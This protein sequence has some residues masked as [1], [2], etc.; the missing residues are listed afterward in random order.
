MTSANDTT[1]QF[2]W[3]NAPWRSA[4]GR[5][6]WTAFELVVMVLGFVVFWPIGLAIL[7]YKMWTRRY[8]GADLQTVATAAYR[9]ARD[10]MSSATPKSGAY[11]DWRGFASGF[12]SRP[13]SSGNRAFDDWKTTQIA[14]LEEERRKLDEQRRKLDEAHKEFDAFVEQVRQAKDREEFERFMRERGQNNG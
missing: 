5:S 2:D 13:A 6:H 3:A 9:Q 1:G 10:A 8:G 14:R 7:I 4:N 12:A 11:P